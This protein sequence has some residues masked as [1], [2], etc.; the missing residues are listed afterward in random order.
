M[1]LTQC[2]VALLVF[3]DMCV[4]K[5]HFRNISIAAAIVFALAFVHLTQKQE[6]LGELDFLLLQ[7]WKKFKFSTTNKSVLEEIQQVQRNLKILKILKA[8]ATKRVIE[9]FEEIFDSLDSIYEKSKDSEIKGVRDALLRHM[10]LFNLFLVDLLQ[11]SNNFFKFLRSR[12]IQFSSFPSKGDRMK[13]RLRKYMENIETERCFFLDYAD[14]YLNVA[15]QRS[16]LSRSTW[17]KGKKSSQRKNESK[18]FYKKLLAHSPKIFLQ[19]PM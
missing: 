14:N 19:K 16:E 13:E 5:V 1:E 18:T 17:E 15:E 9:I 7:L 2:P 10:I 4:L 12:T 6:V 3:K 8:S 11:I